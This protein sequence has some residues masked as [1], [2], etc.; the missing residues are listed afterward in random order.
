[1][2]GDRIEYM[3]SSECHWCKIYKRKR[4]KRRRYDVNGSFEFGDDPFVI[5]GGLSRF[6]VW[7]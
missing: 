5:I 2:K 7:T 6:S 3:L 1:M 4:K